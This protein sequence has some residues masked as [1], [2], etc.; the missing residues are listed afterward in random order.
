MKVLM[1][2][3]T[4]E[5]A[6]FIRPMLRERYGDVVLSSRSEV[7][8]LQEGESSRPADLTDRAALDAAMEGV[9]GI[10][11]LGGQSVED[12]W[13]T[14]L[15]SNIDGLYTFYEA[16]RGAGVNRVVF[17]SSIHAI[18]FYP[19]HRR[20]GPDDPTRPDTRYGLSKVFGEGLASF[21]ADKF[22][23]R[24]LS[25]RIG[26]CVP[27]PVDARLQQIW[28]HPEDFFQLCTIGLEHPDI[29]NQIVF[30]AS[31]NTRNFWDNEP[32]FRLGYRPKH[33]AED[34]ES[35]RS[36]AEE[37]ERDPVADAFQGGMFA[38]E[39]FDGDLDRALWSAR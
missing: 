4:G 20:I 37:T 5:V 28:L 10:I 12:D 33:A 23:I 22:G 31:H 8:D 29:H 25:V 3:A 17:A 11:H 36:L 9:D 7:E 35:P 1:T 39:E 15:K 24:T 13:Q 16:A 14:V 38:A 30:G 26:Q 32:A 6:G 34:Y 21:Y 27:E 2:G 18:G 19:R